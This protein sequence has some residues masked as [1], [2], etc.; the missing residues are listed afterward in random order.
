MQKITPSLWFDN[1]AEEAAKFYVSI[2]PNSKMGTVSRYGKEGFE[3][4]KQPEGTAMVAPF[5]LNGQP[6]IAFNGGPMFKFSEAISFTISCKDQEEI[7][8]YWSKLTEGGQESRCGWLKDKFGLS[9]QVVP[10]ILSQLMADPQRSG[11]VMQAFLKMKKF[12][13]QQLMDA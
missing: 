3:V 11:R 10:A 2:F 4:H 5:E 7:D 1:Q 6:F 12:D 13:I 8:H 9:W